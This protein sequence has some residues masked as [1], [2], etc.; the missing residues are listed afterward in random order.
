MRFLL[1]IF[2]LSTLAACTSEPDPLTE[3]RWELVWADEFRGEAGDSPD[4]EK[5]VYDIG[6]GDNGWG[7]NELQTYTDRPD[8]ARLNGQGFLVITGKREELD[9]SPW[10]SARLKT[11]GTFAFTYGRVEAKIKLPTGKGLWPAFWMLGNNIEEVSW[12]TCGEI[13]IMENFGRS[14]T[15]IAGTIHGPG[16]SAGNAFGGEYE[17]PEAGED[18]G[19]LDITELNV[20]RV[21]WD[22]EHISW[23]VNDQLYHT[24]HPGDVNGPWVMDH[25]FFL[26]MNLAIGGNPVEAPDASTPDTNEMIVDYVR[27]YERRLPIPDPGLA[28]P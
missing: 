7:N 27:V 2:A 25:P 21:D 12:P 8:N 15:R 24:A 28:A 18:G 20:Y 13:D 23:Y 5:W 10:T 17:F 4:S 1:P 14:D 6:T 26:L 9:G 19:G 3:E 16:Y 22:P 11:Q